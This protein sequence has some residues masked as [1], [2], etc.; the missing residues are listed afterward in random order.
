MT[1]ASRAKSVSVFAA[2]VALASTLFVGPP[3][4]GND[5]SS[6]RE[7]AE[8]FRRPGAPLDPV[9]S[10]LAAGHLVRHADALAD[11]GA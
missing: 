9:L 8:R 3:A 11:G 4:S 6:N 5:S 10:A 1:C 7:M 2:G